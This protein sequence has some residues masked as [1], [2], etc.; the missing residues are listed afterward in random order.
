[1]ISIV[2]CSQSP[3]TVALHRHHVEDTAGCTIEY[4]PV[5]NPEGRFGLAEAYNRGVA[6]A[7]GE[8]VVFVHD[9]VFFLSHG[10]GLSLE[11]RFGGDTALG[12]VG[13]AGTSYL[14]RANPLWCS[15]GRPFIH[16]RVIHHDRKTD[17]CLLTVFCSHEQDCEVTA[18]DGLF[19]AIR[20]SLFDTIQFD[21]DTFDRFHFYDLDI[22][23]QVGRV[24]KLIVASDIMVKHFSAGSFG[25][26]WVRYAAVF[27][28]K[29][30]HDLPKGCAAQA[31]LLDSKE[32][33]ETFDCDAIM[34]PNTVATIRALGRVPNEAKPMV[35]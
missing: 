6:C 31:P 29:W 5:L 27:T 1:M 19:F 24:G 16:G 13:A 32:D 30:A 3:Q 25:D 26:A 20:R 17:R 9:D 15:A 8:I 22:S 21:S 4:I 11:K 7:S 33:F 28:R 2:V 34:K 35:Q 14:S 18:V 12:L 23:M 10:W